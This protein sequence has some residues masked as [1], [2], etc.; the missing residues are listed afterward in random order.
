MTVN[1]FNNQL[2]LE[3]PLGTNFICFKRMPE[4]IA[5]C[6]QFSYDRTYVLTDKDSTY[7]TL[8]I[9]GTEWYITSGDLNTNHYDATDALLQLIQQQE[10]QA[11]EYW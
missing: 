3:V 11:Y 7:V 9:R 2:V 4:I 5:F 6:L 8:Y 10:P 1:L